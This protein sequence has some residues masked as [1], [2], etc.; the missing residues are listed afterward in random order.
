MLQGEKCNK[1][2]QKELQNLF[3][4]SKDVSTDTLLYL[5]LRGFCAYKTAALSVSVRKIETKKAEI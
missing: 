1:S 2:V 3:Y 4:V 5:S